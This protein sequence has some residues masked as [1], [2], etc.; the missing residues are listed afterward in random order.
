MTALIYGETHG[1]AETIRV[2]TIL[3]Q[4]RNLNVGAVKKRNDASIGTAMRTIF[5]PVILES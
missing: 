4:H 3:Q 2:H 5:I 1:R